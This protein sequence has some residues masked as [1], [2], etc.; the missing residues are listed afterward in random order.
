MAV[1][2]LSAEDYI[3]YPV[4]IS[5]TRCWGVRILYTCLC[6]SDISNALILNVFWAAPLMESVR[7]RSNS[8]RILYTCPCGS[9]ISVARRA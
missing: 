5:A 3:K 9:G 6:G 1:S 7:I 4:R 8:V 2:D